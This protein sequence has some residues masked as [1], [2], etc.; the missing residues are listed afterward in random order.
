M[1]TGEIVGA[2]AMTEPG[3]GS[4]LQGV[5]TSAI[6]KGNELVING[7]KTFITNGQ[8]ADVV[9][10]VAKTDPSKGAKGTSLVLVERGRRLDGGRGLFD[11]AAAGRV[12]HRTGGDTEERESK[13]C[14]AQHRP[15]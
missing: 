5:K 9:I 3:T 7:S 4:D 6:Q 1:A 2:I 14:A 15:L 13:E 8:L 12:T 11:G 10:V